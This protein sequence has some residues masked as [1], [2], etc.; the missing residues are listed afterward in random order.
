MKRVILS[1]ALFVFAFGAS[2]QLSRIQFFTTAVN[3]QQKP[4]EVKIDPKVFDDYAGQYVFAENPDLVLSFFREGANYFL[5]VSS[6]GRI[7]IYPANTSKFFTKMLDADASFVRDEQGRVI[8][9]VWRHG[10]QTSRAQKTSAQ[11]AVE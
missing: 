3:A 6:Q 7:Q 1:F 11:P 9:V 5:Q 4:A 8:A 10:D 2:S